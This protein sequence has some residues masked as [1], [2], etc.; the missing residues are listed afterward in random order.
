MIETNANTGVNVFPLNSATVIAVY[1]LVPSD[2]PL[3]LAPSCA[4]TG[5]TFTTSGAKVGVS[6]TDVA[7]F[8]ANLIPVKTVDAGDEFAERARHPCVH[9]ISTLLLLR[10]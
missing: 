4:G 3:N 9:Q 5:N 10:R 7:K 2:Q 1:R 6:L 8:K